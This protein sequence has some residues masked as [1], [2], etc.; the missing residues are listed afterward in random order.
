MPQ[1]RF[2]LR[3]KVC[4]G[5]G[6]P[7]P[8][9]LRR[10]VTKLA[11][12]ASRLWGRAA[13]VHTAEDVAGSLTPLSLGMWQTAQGMMSPTTLPAPS[14]GC[15]A[16]WC[17]VSPLEHLTGLLS[18]LAGEQRRQPYGLSSCQHHGLLLTLPGTFSEAS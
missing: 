10:G 13:A 9:L 6:A 11:G 2:A 7:G 3:L 12:R 4:S 5:S 16:V 18:P 8:I 1:N 14:L 15:E 17:I